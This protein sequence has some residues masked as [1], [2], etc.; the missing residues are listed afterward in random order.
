M[1][2]RR[3][4]IPQNCWLPCEAADGYAE[5]QPCEA[6]KLL[7]RG[8]HLRLGQLVVLG[9]NNLRSHIASGLDFGLL[10]WGSFLIVVP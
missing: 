1:H 10:S 3:S 5:T 9:I 4:L 8:V 7:G 2:P 6:D